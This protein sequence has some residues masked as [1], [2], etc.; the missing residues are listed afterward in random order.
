MKKHLKRLSGYT[1][2]ELCLVVL[3]LS[4]L[5]AAAARYSTSATAARNTAELNNTLKT[6]EEALRSYSATYARLPCPSDITLA[7][8]SASFGNEVGTAGDGNCAGYNFINS[9]ADPDAADPDYVAS[10]NYVVA[11]GVPTKTLKLDDRFAYDPWGRRLLFAL[12]KRISATDAFTTYT[13]TDTAIGAI[14]IKQAT[15]DTLASANTY[16]AIY[17]LVSFGANGHGGYVRNVSATSTRFNNGSTNTGEQKNCHCDS[18]A[19]ATAFDRIFVR[20]AKTPSTT[21]TNSYDDVVTFKTRA[22]LATNA[23]LQ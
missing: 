16:K 7:D 17:A 14:V 4:L 23:Q 5:A 13:F 6:I 21:L 11:G 12:D 19:I 15:T 2:I 10:T 8:N 3:I 1:L 9:G 22:Q 20:T 18:S